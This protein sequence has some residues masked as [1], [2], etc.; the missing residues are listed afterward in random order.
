[1]PDNNLHSSDY[2]VD[3]RVIQ[4]EWWDQDAHIRLCLEH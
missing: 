2:D 3:G 1:M 4:H